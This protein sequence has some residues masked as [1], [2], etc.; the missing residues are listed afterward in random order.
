MAAKSIYE[1]GDFPRRKPSCIVSCLEMAEKIFFRSSC[2]PERYL[3]EEKMKI[4]LEYVYKK[5]I[6]FL[7]QNKYEYIVIGGIA[8][9]VLGEPRFTADVDI[10]ILLN[11]GQIGEFLNKAKKAGFKFDVKICKNRIKGSG[12]FQINCGDF[13]I[14]FI[15]ASTAFEKEAFRRKQELSLYG[16]KAFFP[17]SEDLILLKV[18]PGRFQDL[19]DIEKIITRQKEKLDVKYLENWAGQLSDEAQDARIIN[20]LQKF[21][22]QRSKK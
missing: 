1:K 4:S 15:I 10:D 12:T 6:G 17:T 20:E 22:G 9:G 3:E 7:K 14:D 16:I 11:K 5:I 8:A 21:L 19:S 18:I 13:H 2:L